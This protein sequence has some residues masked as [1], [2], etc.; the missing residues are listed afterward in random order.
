MKY[1]LLLCYLCPKIKPSTAKMKSQYIVNP[2]NILYTIRD[3]KN[4]YR[5]LAVSILFDDVMQ[6]NI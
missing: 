6:F 4:S 2:I 3:L 1:I 5:L